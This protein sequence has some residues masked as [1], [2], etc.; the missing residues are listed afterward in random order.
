M[1]FNSVQFFCGLSV[2]YFSNQFY[3][4]ADSINT[5]KEKISIH[6]KEIPT[7]EKCFLLEILFIYNC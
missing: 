2:L 5:F 7:Y 4:T 1:A 6:G 3:V